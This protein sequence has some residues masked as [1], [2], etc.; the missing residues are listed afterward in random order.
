MEYNFRR[1]QGKKDIPLQ[2]RMC[3]IDSI[4][5]TCKVSRFIKIKCSVVIQRSY[6]AIIGRDPFDQNF[7]KFRSKT[8]WIGSVQP[9][10][11]E[12]IGPPFEV[13]HFSR[14]DRT[15]RNGLFHLTIPTH[16]QSQYQQFGIL[17]VQHGRKH[18]LCSFYRLFT[19]NLSVLLLTTLELL[20]KPSVCS[21]C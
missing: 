10:K 3:F 19:A 9:E 1:F 11:F 12:K 15:D 7:R 2:R 6:L 20:H 8:E 4:S 16:S 18:L 14:L 13:D 21:G 17:H 5:T